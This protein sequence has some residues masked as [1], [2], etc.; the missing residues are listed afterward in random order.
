MSEWETET[1]EELCDFRNGL[2]KGKKPPYVDVGIIRNTNFTREGFLNDSEIAFHPVEVKQYEKRKLEFG[3]IILEKSGGG[4]KQ[5]VGRVIPFEMTEGEFS[6]SNFTSVIRIKNKAALHY[7]YLHRLLYHYYI[8]GVT[9]SMQRRSTGI[10]NLDFKTYKQLPIPL[11]P[12]A[13]QKRIV[14]ILDEAFGAIAKAKENAERNLANAKELFESYLNRVFTEKGEGWQEKTLL[15]LV[16]EDCPISYGIV[17]PGGDVVDGL[18]VVRPVDFSKP[19]V[20]LDGVKQIDPMKAEAYQRTVL[21]GG[22]LL[23][24][25]RGTTGKI[26]TASSVLKGANVTRGI[27]PIRFNTQVLLNAFGLL[28]MK[29]QVVQK[30]IRDHTTGTALKQINIRE[31]RKITLPYPPLSQ[32]AVI[33]KMLDSIFEGSSELERFSQQKLADLDE[34]KQSILQKAFTGQLTSKSPELEA[35]G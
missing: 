1:L 18:P 31:L 9:E 17:Q 23:L 30:Q 3:D 11:P 33:S 7:Q 14:S 26:A 22:E 25:V 8:S 21:Q 5:P 32:Q 10:R 28:A 29:S 27:V 4:P 15:E 16:T 19:V 2:W 20:D 24:C 35:V 6:F 12:L 34:L 13:E